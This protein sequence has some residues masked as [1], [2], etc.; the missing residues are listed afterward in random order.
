[1]SHYAALHSIVFMMGFV[2]MFD[3]RHHRHR[4]CRLFD[5]VMLMTPQELDLIRKIQLAGEEA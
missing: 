3:L 2:Y 4:L 5:S 1:M